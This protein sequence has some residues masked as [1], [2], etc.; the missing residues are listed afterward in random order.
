MGVCFLV[1]PLYIHI[2]FTDVSYKSIS[3]HRLDEVVG[4]SEP[5]TK[6]LKT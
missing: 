6:V 1:V 2:M 4:K 3:G 5:E